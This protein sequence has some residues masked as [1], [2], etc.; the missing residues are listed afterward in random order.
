MGTKHRYQLSCEI[1]E[2]GHRFVLTSNGKLAFGAI[3]SET[4]LTP[5]PIF[6][7]H[8]CITNPETNDG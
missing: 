5:G 2:K 7:S 4:S 6:L 8:G 3:K 1:D